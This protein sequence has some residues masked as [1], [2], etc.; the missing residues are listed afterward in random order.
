MSAIKSKLHTGT[1]DKSAERKPTVKKK[2]AQE[3][4]I[5][6]K[7]REAEKNNNNTS[8]SQPKTENSKITNV[9]DENALDDADQKPV[10]PS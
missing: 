2:T 6:E 10:D 9:P 4:E 7:E 1:K 8:N 5:Q 3:E